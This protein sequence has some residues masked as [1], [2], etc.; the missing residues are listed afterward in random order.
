MSEE[1]GATIFGGLADAA[2]AAWDAAENV[3]A[4][5]YD[6]A[7]GAV[8]MTEAVGDNFAAAGNEFIGD[9]AARDEWDKKLFENRD[10][11]DA[12]FSDAGQ[13]L[14]NAADDVF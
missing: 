14:Q 9:Y 3:A 1:E 8:S 2:G 5:G 10:A 7:S 4:A 13:D 11:S 6:A 12:S